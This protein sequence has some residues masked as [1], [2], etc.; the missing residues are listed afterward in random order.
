VSENR[1]KTMIEYLSTLSSIFKEEKLSKFTIL[2][3]DDKL[4]EEEE[5]KEF[6]IFNGGVVFTQASNE[7]SAEKVEDIKKELPNDNEASKL[8]VFLPVTNE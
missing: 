1:V 4:E 5:I 3:R 2:H 8:T 6:E 7:S